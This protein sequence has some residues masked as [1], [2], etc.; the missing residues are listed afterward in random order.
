MYFTE[1]ILWW[2]YC[3]FLK[4]IYGISAIASYK[5]EEALK[6]NNKK[7]VCPKC[8]RTNM[9]FEVHTSAENNKPSHKNP[10]D[11]TTMWN[12]MNL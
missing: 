3:H 10:I 2:N 11:T 1:G 6:N 7:N 4:S 9:K 5:M 12:R 8:P